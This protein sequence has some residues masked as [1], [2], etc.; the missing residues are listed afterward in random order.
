MFSGF[1]A[2]KCVIVCPSSLSSAAC[3]LVL[4]PKAK[5]QHRVTTTMHWL[6]LHF[7]CRS[8]GNPEAG[9]VW[10]RISVVQNLASHVLTTQPHSPTLHGENGDGDADNF[11]DQ[12]LPWGKSLAH[13][14][15][16]NLYSYLKWV[17]TSPH[18]QWGSG[19][20]EV[21]CLSVEGRDSV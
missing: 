1:L 20:K 14:F 17:T 12:P 16:L 11:H 15:P 21:G 7:S 8:C 13:V 18:N 3:L 9:W 10:G 2:T 19:V 5:D 4:I 6:V